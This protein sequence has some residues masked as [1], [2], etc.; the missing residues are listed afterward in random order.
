MNKY[1]TKIAEMDSDQKTHIRQGVAGALGAGLFG[2]VVHTAANLHGILKH[3]DPHGFMSDQNYENMKRHVA[4]ESNS[5]FNDRDAGLPKGVLDGKGPAYLNKDHFNKTVGRSSG[6][7]MDKNFIHLDENGAHG[8]GKSKMVG[9]HEMGHAMDYR[10][11]KAFGGKLLTGSKILGRGPV[12]GAV[13]AGM[14]SNDKTRDYAPVVPLIGHA[15]EL[16]S[17]ANANIKG[18]KLVKQF[19]GNTSQ[20]R[21]FATKQWMGYASK[22]LAGAVGLGIAAHLIKKHNEKK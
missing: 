6:I 15:P 4:T 3:K 2:D 19:G 7:H 18:H 21:R 9:A 22:P 20:F 14:L 5:T 8:L 16:I 1:L 10:N 12:A 11:G 17:E 13:A